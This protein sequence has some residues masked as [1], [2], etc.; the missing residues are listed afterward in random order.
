MALLLGGC[1]QAP[2]NGTAPPLPDTPR[3]VRLSPDQETPAWQPL[4]LPGKTPT[5]Y[6][7]DR[8]EGRPAWR[9]Q[10][11]LS[12]SMWRRKL[13]VAPSDLGE[14]QFSWWVSNLLEGADLAERGQGDSPARLVFAFDGDTGRLGFQ[15]RMMAEMAATL[16]GEAMPYATLMYV[17]SNGSA[18]ESVITNPRTG[19]VRKIVLES[20]PGPLRQWRDYRRNLVEDFRRAFG[21][22]PG[23]LVA[24]GLMTD[25]DNTRTRTTTWYG[26]VQLLAPV[27]AGVGAAPPAVSAPH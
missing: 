19:R 11:D 6:Q 24:V 21:E 18:P 15:D 27:A 10:A 13:Y 1:A 2:S 26:E 12:A 25:T 9:A 3:V 23:P 16:T 14:V 7:P 4:L 5:R 20:G 22:A 17:W 8:K